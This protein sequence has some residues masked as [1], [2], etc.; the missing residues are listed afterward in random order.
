MKA[1]E[2]H[3]NPKQGGQEFDQGESFRPTLSEPP[4]NRG[5]LIP[6][7]EI[8][9]EQCAEGVNDY[10]DSEQHRTFVEREAISIAVDNPATK[11]SNEGPQNKHCE[12]AKDNS[13]GW[14][15]HFLPRCLRALIRFCNLTFLF[16]I[17]VRPGGG[18]LRGE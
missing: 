1:D 18:W 3:Q 15:H 17:P 8:C 16:S 6:R 13:A 7:G 4:G 5:H 9:E 10:R 11:G 2:D 14:M 12:G